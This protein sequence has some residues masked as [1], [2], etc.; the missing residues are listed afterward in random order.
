MTSDRRKAAI[1]AYKERKSVAGI[2][3]LR[4]RASGAV[5]VGQSPTLESIQNRIWFTLRLGSHPSPA[6]QKAWNDHGADSLAFEVVERLPEEES[7]YVRNAT[8]R[9]RLAHWQARLNA[10]VLA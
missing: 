5:W 6:L 10:A 7:A 8:L 4:C 2:Y 9:E 1:A 3:L